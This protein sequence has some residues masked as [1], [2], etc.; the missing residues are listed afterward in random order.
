[1]CPVST[2]SRLSS[3]AGFRALRRWREKHADRPDLEERVKSK[4]PLDAAGRVRSPATIR[5][6]SASRCWT[7]SDR[8]PI[9]IAA[10]T[11]L[12]VLAREAQVRG[13]G[14]EVANAELLHDVGAG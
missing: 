11:S 7:A 5:R 2:I 9:L 6:S 3:A 12:T 13:R 8:A 1:M 10:A 4:I 14:V